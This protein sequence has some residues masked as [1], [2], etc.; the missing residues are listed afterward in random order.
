MKEKK[1]KE[2][3]K[4]V[5]EEMRSHQYNVETDE[6]AIKSKM[7]TADWAEYNEDV[8]VK[9][10]TMLLNL[11]NY[12]NNVNINI[13]DNSFSI[14][15]DNLSSIKKLRTSNGNGLTKINDDDYFSV[16]I[17][18]ET[19]FC[20]NKGYN[21]RTNYLDP[22]IYDDILPIATRK[23]KEINN[24]NFNNIWNDIMKESGLMR[25]NNIDELLKNINE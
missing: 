5:F 20:I 11:I 10:K 14:S 19:G 2:I 7:Y 12:R 8:S 4:T 22:K 23:L 21:M 15:T 25:D 13:S 1:L 3:V 9:L 24:E 16:E 6:R 18:K 17:I